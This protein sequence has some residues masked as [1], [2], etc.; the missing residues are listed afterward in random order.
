MTIHLKDDTFEQEVLKST[1]PVLVDFNASWCGPCQMLSPVIEELS[2]DFSGRAKV[3]KLDTDECPE[4]TKRYKVMT[5]PTLIFFNNGEI[6]DKVVGVVPKTMLSEKL[7][8]I[9]A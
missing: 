5:V 1:V 4:M 3:C 8:G 9:L 6:V 2:G 7:E